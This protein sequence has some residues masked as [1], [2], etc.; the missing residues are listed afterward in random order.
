MVHL[1]R[2]PDQNEQQALLLTP[3][4]LSKFEEYGLADKLI[5]MGQT[6]NTIRIFEDAKLIGR[7]DVGKLGRTHNYL[8]AVS[9]DDVCR[10]LE[11]QLGDRVNLCHDSVENV[12]LSEGDI[13]VLLKGERTLSP[14]M[15]IAA[16]GG[17]SVIRTAL[18]IPYIGYDYP[19]DWVYQDSKFEE[20]DGEIDLV[21]Y[22]DRS[23]RL[24]VKTGENRL[25]LYSNVPE[26]ERP[27]PA[28]IGSLDLGAPHTFKVF[29][30]Q[31]KDYARGNVF[32]TGH[33]A[34]GLGP[35]G[36]VSYGCGFADVFDLAERIQSEGSDASGVLAAYAAERRRHGAEMLERSEMMFKAMHM[37][38]YWQRSLRAYWLFIARVIPGFRRA[39]LK[40]IAGV[41]R[42]TAA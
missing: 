34:H 10:V 19:L 40:R 7:F 13:E 42:D 1:C 33:T 5:G 39:V 3:F 6:L 41:D 36:G 2:P 9:Y 32:L 27:L 17:N 12:R 37:N 38:S 21:F 28:F 26:L 35:L 16:D 18:G 30:R 23:M 8:L 24:F 31:A 20:W 25:R 4:I 11:A 14:D 15:L 22:A 29:K